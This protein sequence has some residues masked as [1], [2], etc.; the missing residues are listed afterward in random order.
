[1]MVAL[2]CLVGFPLLGATLGFSIAFLIE[3]AGTHHPHAMIGIPAIVFG[4]PAGALAG[5][6]ATVVAVRRKAT[7]RVPLIALAL[8]ALIGFAFVGWFVASGR[9]W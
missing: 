5:L 1:M 7:L 9:R 2:L 4:A 6:I 8:A 3:A